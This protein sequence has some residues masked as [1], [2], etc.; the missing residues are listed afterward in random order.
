MDVC[1]LVQLADG[2]GGYFAP[3]ESLCDV[4][5]TAHGDAS[6]I[7][8]NECFFYAA[9]PAAIPLND[10][11]LERDSLETGHIERDVAGCGGK[12]SAVMAAAVALTL[13]A[14]LVL[15]SLGK[16]L[17]FCLQQTVE[18]LFYTAP[19]QFLDLPL[20]NFLVKL[21]NFLGHGLLSPF[22]MV[23]RD[24]ILPEIC[25]PCPF[26]FFFQFAQFILP[27]LLGQSD[28]EDVHGEDNG[29]HQYQLFSFP[30]H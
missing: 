18:R 14:A 13:L 24:F 27:Y 2:G 25:K 29:Q 4:L 26:S 22:R 8:L 16:F 30:A 21:Y 11:G 12:V 1:L 6:Q 20:D 5:H 7:H 19:D 23:C 15:G 28:Y 10:G 3:P 17:G 9:F